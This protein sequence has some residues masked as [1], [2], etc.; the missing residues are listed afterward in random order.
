M[1]EQLSGLGI[2]ELKSFENQL[3]MSLKNVQIKKDQILS[4][5]IKD[6]E[7]TGH[8]IHRETVHLHKTIEVIRKE[9]AEL[10]T[11]PSQP[12]SQSTDESPAKAMELGHKSL[13]TDEINIHLE[14][15]HPQLRAATELEGTRYDC[16]IFVLNFMGYG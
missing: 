13:Q 11:K 5:G 2:N 15:T 12:E 9:N 8:Q 4:G 1:G 16:W 14:Q 10:Q 6:L 7:H 3:E